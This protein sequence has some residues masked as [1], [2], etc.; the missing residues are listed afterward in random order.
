MDK[1]K[2]NTRKRIFWALVAL[3]ISAGLNAQTPEQIS[4]YTA[5]YDKALL[6]KMAADI[7]ARE[8]ADKEAAWEYAR[9]K[10]IPVQVTLSDGGK[11]ELMKREADGTLIY[12]RT[13]NVA[14][15]RSTRVNHLNTGG[16]TGYNLDG[17]NMFA[18]VWDEAHA[19]LTHQEFDGAGGTDRVSVMDASTAT[20][21]SHGCHVTG[22]IVA[23][24]VTASAKGMAPQGR[25]RGYNWTSDLSEA[26]TA[27]SNGMLLSNHS[28][29]YSQSGLASY[30][31]GAYLTV[32]RDWDNLMYNAPY[33]LM[34]KSAG[35]NGTTTYNIDPLDPSQP[36][37]DKLTDRTTCKNNLAIA[38][39][40][41]ASVDVNGNLTSVTI[42]SFSSQGPTD[43]LRIKPDIAA[44]GASL[45]STDIGADNS[46]STKSGTSMA[47]P[48]ATGTLL[49]LQQH[50]YQTNGAYMRA[51]TLKG[52]VLHTADDV[53]MTGPDAVWGWGLMNGLRAAR[54]ISSNGTTAQISELLL[55]QGQTYTYTVNSDGINKLM[56]S[57]SWTD[58][59]GTAT[60]A[61]NSTTPRLVND[62]DIRISKNG[63]TYLP[64]M[65]TGVNT[66]TLGDNIR[67][68]FERA[69][70][71]G[72]FGTYTITVSHKGT[73]SSGSQRFSLII[74]G[75][76]PQ[77]CTASIPDPVTIG[78]VL[79]NSA[80]ISWSAVQLAT[81]NYRFRMLGDTAWITQGTAS[82]SATL[83]GLA[84]LSTYEFQVQS[85]CPDGTTSDWTNPVQFSTPQFV[86]TYCNSSGISTQ[87]W[88]QSIQIGQSGNVSGNDGGYGN[89]TS[90]A[91]DIYKGQNYPLTIQPGWAATARAEGYSVWIDY[92][93]NGSFNDAGEQVYTRSATT[94]TPVSGTVAIP[95]TAVT[96]PVRM[97]VSM[98]YNAIPTSCET[99]FAG[100]VEDYTLNLLD[101]IV[102]VDAP[103]APTQ[104]T[105]SSITHNSLSLSWI[106]ST[107]NVL[108]TGYK[109]YM[110]GTLFSTVTSTS[111]AVTGLSPNTLYSF[112][113]TAI[114]AAG[115]NSAASNQVD[116][117][118]LPFV[119]TYCTSRG[120]STSR[121]FINRVR[122]GS[123]DNT[124]GNNSG[125]GNFTALSTTMARG[126]SQT[127]TIN[128]GW[129]STARSEAY[130]VWIDYN[131]DGDFV[132]AGEQVFSRNKT[133]ATSVSGTFTVPS[134]AIIGATRMR[135]SMKYNSNPTSCEVFASG[136]VEDYTIQ[137]AATPS[138][139]ASVETPVQSTFE[140]DV[141]P[142]PVNGILFITMDILPELFEVTVQDMNGRMI[143][144]N[145][146]VDRIDVSNLQGGVYL[147]R[148]SANGEVVTR[149]FIK[150]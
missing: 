90:N 117:T 53:G 56:A 40:N 105:A 18:C 1:R 126:T 10:N 138:A 88:I 76:V 118:T 34:V 49:L 6:A 29:G 119:V 25:V 74:T 46:Y 128:P 69:E 82:I 89:F 129:T 26:T 150:E 127:I 125:Y 45:Y 116:V 30:Y 132:D 104:L 106:A 135:V 73:L 68:P 50:A 20:L 91:I 136:E 7:G 65:L 122:V 35:N 92:N 134:T 84:Q 143:M 96:G 93:F 4:V 110:N 123:I 137:I 98:K 102:D 8:K 71:S 77:T 83:T 36:Q 11:A 62:L 87:E 148:I 22:T 107:D 120:N 54:T 141:F 147:L 48:N 79:Y 2:P 57:I 112:Y 3:I 114:D 146:N 52:L 144:E 67:D 38:S 103:T 9:L 140:F 32:A 113:V 80:S 33:Y 24:G 86:V 124:S 149:K 108:V 101:P 59:A 133:T 78:N 41:D 23:S 99:G 5:E 142:N 85:V 72:A 31:F 27:A 19:R 115:N 17:Q 14:A 121:E 16:S 81:Y 43:D 97:R 70:V 12:F 58:P 28:Y 66:N 63:T 109:V 47:S 42:S 130:R 94:I 100:E 61:L 64:W 15:A 95:L 111:L 75:I 39:A 55:S 21:S 37:Y 13:D 60:T 51:A 145:M 139:G 44:N 131:G